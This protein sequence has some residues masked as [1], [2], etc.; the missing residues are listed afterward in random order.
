MPI[1]EQSQ[2]A[3]DSGGVYDARPNAPAHRRR[4]VG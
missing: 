2:R 1:A 4:V 3:K